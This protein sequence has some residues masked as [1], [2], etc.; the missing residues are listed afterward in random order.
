MRIVFMGTPEFAASCLRGVLE[1]GYDVA[2]VYT[3]PDRPKGRKGELCASPVKEYA[4][5]RGIPVYQ[6]ERIRRKAEVETL[7]NLQPDLIL[8][9]AYG[10]ILNKAILDMAP[11]INAHASLLPRYRGSSPIQRAIAAGDTVTGVTAMRMDEGVDTGNMILTRE[12]PITDQ[13]TGDSLE[14]KLAQAGAEALVAVLKAWEAGDNLIGT[15]QDESQATYAPMLSREDGK[16]DWNLSA[17][18]MDQA[19][20]AFT[21]WPSSYTLWKGKPLKVQAV[22][23]FQETGRPGEHPNG[24]VFN[25]EEAAALGAKPDW[26]ILVQTGEGV[27]ELCQLQLPGKKS[28]PADVFLRGCPL[29]GERLGEDEDPSV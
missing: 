4:L 6:P 2:A 26:Q 21:S 25:R 27:L 9:A 18:Q 16:M 22:R 13:D 19:V 11:C 10:Q 20:R 1:A 8:V 15:P 17:R 28:L 12:V 23:V 7:R 14:K 3:Q 5:S 24:T 29:W